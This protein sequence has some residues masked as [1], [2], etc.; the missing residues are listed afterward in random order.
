MATISAGELNL[1]EFADKVTWKLLNFSFTLWEDDTTLQFGRKL[2]AELLLIKDWLATNRQ[3]AKVQNDEKLQRRVATLLRNLERICSW[4]PPGK[5]RVEVQVPLSRQ[6]ISQVEGSTVY[7]NAA[8][9]LIPEATIPPGIQDFARLGPQGHQDSLIFTLKQF[10]KGSRDVKQ[11]VTTA[12][13]SIEESG[14]V[15]EED[16]AFQDSDSSSDEFD[17]SSSKPSSYYALSESSTVPAVKFHVLFLDHPHD[18]KL[19]RA[20]HWQYTKISVTRPAKIRFED[21]SVKK[22]KA[23]PVEECEYGFCGLIS[24]Q[25][26]IS[27]PLIVSKGQLSFKHPRQ[28]PGG[29][30]LG[31]PSTPLTNIVKL[32]G[33][34]FTQKMRLILS[35]LLAKAVWQ[36][37]ESEWMTRNWTKD[38]V[39]FMFES[40]AGERGIFVDGP[41]L[42]T[43][44]IEELDGRDTNERMR[45]HKFPKILALGIMLIELE[46]RVK[47]EDCRKPNSVRPDGTLSINADAIAAE[48]LIKDKKMWRNTIGGL[49]DVIQI[50]LKPSKFERYRKDVQGQRKQLYKHIVRPLQKLCERAFQGDLEV[51]PV[52]LPTLTGEHDADSEASI[53][54]L[55][56]MYQY[57]ISLSQPAPLTDGLRTRSA[58][59]DRQLS[60]PTLGPKSMSEQL[61]LANG[62]GS[63]SADGTIAT[64]DTWFELLDGLNSLLRA[65]PGETDDSYKAVRVAVIDTGID[66]KYASQIAKYKDYVTETETMTDLTSHGTSIVRLILKTLNKA[67]IYVVRVAE[68]DRMNDDTIISKTQARTAEAIRYATTKWEVDIIT[69]ASGFES[70]NDDMRKAIVEAKAKDVLVFAAASNYGNVKRIAFPARLHYDV[71]C[72]FSTN[73]SVKHSQ[74]NPQPSP[75]LTHNLAVFGEGVQLGPSEPKLMGT[76]FSTAVGAG[77]AA[78]LIDFSR[79]KDSRENLGPELPYLKLVD[80]MSSVFARMAGGGADN[81]YHCVAPWRLLED[82]DRADIDIILQK[83]TLVINIPKSILVGGVGIVPRVLRCKVRPFR[84]GG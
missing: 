37:Y 70:D 14:E 74:F 1:L 41:F 9:L 49:K 72:M 29:F 66:S 39:H 46:L 55:L 47:I 28:Y 71:M 69:L 6:S 65:R 50:C 84:D 5:N 24:S 17:N 54:D 67:R 31:T 10:I 33:E 63:M 36:F 40:R 27:L 42:H 8:L 80:G 12:A 48:Q 30:D 13:S 35:Y 76:S 16:L 77:L 7:P 62:D 83:Q 78:R 57:E 60:R 53:Q 21:R 25:E 81:G 26:P 59:A 75:K 73:A 45:I 18:P 56:D 4:T 11:Q 15:P 23:N 43:S 22:T 79:H 2:S 61:P 38:A 34:Q 19:E 68:R 58:D 82:L 52:L 64:S 44:F 51:A 20:C 3:V 32:H